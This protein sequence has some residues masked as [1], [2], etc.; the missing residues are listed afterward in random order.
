MWIKENLL[1]IALSKLPYGTKYIVWSDADLTFREE[2][3]IFIEEYHKLWIN[4][5]LHNYLNMH[6]I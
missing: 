5:L 2:K 1:N 4:I 6:M 3:I